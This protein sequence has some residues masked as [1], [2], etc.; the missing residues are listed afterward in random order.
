MTIV[1]TDKMKVSS[2][3][4]LQ[5]VSKAKVL[6]AMEGKSL[7]RWIEDLTENA[8][9]EAERQGVRLTLGGGE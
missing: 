2:Y 3:M 7:S 9:K 5:T 8:I 4:D 1:A 6:A